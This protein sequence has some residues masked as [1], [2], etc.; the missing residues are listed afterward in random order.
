[1]RSAL[2]LV[3]MIHAKLPFSLLR[4][5][6]LATIALPFGLL[7]TNKI[8]SNT[9]MHLLIYSLKHIEFIIYERYNIESVCTCTRKNPHETAMTKQ[10]KS[11]YPV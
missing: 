4:C 8:K 7:H 2:K 1:M 10:K 11:S 5:F 3:H 6:S 9:G